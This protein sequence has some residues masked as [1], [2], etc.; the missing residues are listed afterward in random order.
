[1]AMSLTEAQHTGYA[2]RDAEAVLKTVW[3]QGAPEPP[4]PVD[5]I[6]IAHELGIE[7]YIA[8]LSE[9][10]SG[11]LVKR[12]GVDPQIYLQESDHRNRQ[13]F[14]C[15]HELGHYVA[16]EGSDTIEYV[17][18]R[19][20]L[21]S[22]GSNPDEIYAN[23]FAAALLM[24]ADAVKERWRERPNPALLAYDFGVSADAMNFRV[25]NLKLKRS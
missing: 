4:L 14:T 15:A 2:E 18:H 25:V 24:P 9:G 16:S 20:L 11:M 21:A 12:P 19:A 8:T 7:V 3:S 23:Q 1:M 5:P 22:Q 13:R 17:E 6:Y 10:V